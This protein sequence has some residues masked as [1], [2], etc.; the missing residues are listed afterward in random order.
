MEDRGLMTAF[1]GFLP[2]IGKQH[3]S[4]ATLVTLAV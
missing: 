1:W 3:R 4:D 2:S